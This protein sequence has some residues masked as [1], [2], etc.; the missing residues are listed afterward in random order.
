MSEKGFLGSK[1]GIAVIVIAVVVVGSIGGFLVLNSMNQA[2]AEEYYAISYHW[3]FAFYDKNFNEVQNITVNASTHVKIFLLS[4]SGLTE[5][6]HSTFEQRTMM[7]GIGGE[8]NA[9]VIME[10]METAED[11]GKLDHGLAISGYGSKASAVT[12]IADGVT[13]ATSI[14]D[15]ATKLRDKNALPT[16]DFTADKVG[17]FNIICTVD[18][19][20]YHTDMISENAFIVI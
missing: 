10:A 16:I 13:N 1:M 2:S 18:C 5:E 6:L 12:D 14:Q 7:N 9:T 4:A 20:E 15:L 19:G 17:S 11:A 3:G 8:T